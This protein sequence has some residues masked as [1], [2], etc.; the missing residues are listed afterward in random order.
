MWLRTGA[1]KESGHNLMKRPSNPPSLIQTA[2]QD[3]ARKL[4]AK[5]IALG[6]LALL[7]A[8]A[9]GGLLLIGKL[10]SGPATPERESFQAANASITGFQGKTGLGSDERATKLA[11]DYSALLAAGQK[12]AFTGGKDEKSRISLTGGNFITWCE[13]RDDRVCFLVHVPQLKNYKGDVRDALVDLAWQA[14]RE[15]APPEAKQI[16]IGLRGAVLYGAVAI[17]ERGSEHPALCEVSGSVATD[18]LLPFFAP[19]SATTAA[20]V[21]EASGQR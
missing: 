19:A 11:S 15:V 12:A 21:T 8:A 10:T 7:G 4:I 9:L 17:G 5:V 20:A 6:C 2:A 3:A 13:R 18:P 1:S 14:A 16:A